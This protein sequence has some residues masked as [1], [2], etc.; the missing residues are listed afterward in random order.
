MPKEDLRKTED[1]SVQQADVPVASTEI[2]AIELPWWRK[3]LEASGISEDVLAKMGASKPYVVSDPKAV[4]FDILNNPEG[5]T[6]SGTIEPRDLGEVLAFPYPG[7]TFERDGREIPFTRI[8]P[9]CPRLAGEFREWIKNADGTKRKL[10]A[11]ERMQLQNAEVGEETH[12]GTLCSGPSGYWCEDNRKP[13]KYESPRKLGQ[14]IYDVIDIFHPEG[15]RATDTLY[16]IEGEK[17]ALCANANLGLKAYGLSGV[18][19]AHDIEATQTA[20]D[21]GSGSY[22]LH[23]KILAHCGRG[24]IVTTMFD[25]PDVGKNPQV[26]RAQAT[27]LRAVLKAGGK[28]EITYMPDDLEHRR[29][30]GIDD[31]FVECG[32]E[33]VLNRVFDCPAQPFE[34]LKAYECCEKGDIMNQLPRCLSLHAGAWFANDRFLLKKWVR[35]ATKV[36]DTEEEQVMEWCNE[37]ARVCQVTSQ[38]RIIKD[39]ER[40][41]ELLLGK[42]ELRMDE[43]TEEIYLGKNLLRVDSAVTK[44]RANLS[45]V[46]NRIGADPSRDDV[47]DGIRHIAERSSFHPVREYLEDLPG[48]DRATRMESAI[49]HLGIAESSRDPLQAVLFRKFLIAGVARTFEPGCKVDTML[50]LHGPQGVQKSSLFRALCSAP[51]WFTDQNFAVGDKDAVLTINRFWIV[52]WS[53]L[54]NLRRASRREELKGFVSRSVD[55]VRPPYGRCVV[56]MK[57]SCI[58]CGTT[59]EEM[60]LDD[61]TGHRR[62]WI[63]SDV[64]NVDVHWFEK[65]RDLLWAEALAAYRAEEKWWLDQSQEERLKRLQCRHEVPSQWG[66]IIEDYLT[67]P[68]VVPNGIG[69]SATLPPPQNVTIT[70]V[71]EKAIGKAKDRQNKADQREV[72]EVLKSLGWRK[73]DSRHRSNNRQVSW[74]MPSPTTSLAAVGESGGQNVSL[75]ATPANCNGVQTA[76]GLMMGEEHSIAPREGFVVDELEPLPAFCRAAPM[77]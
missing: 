13:I 45:L 29:K 20:M 63:I 9:K 65:N 11:R 8:K 39:I 30:R 15:L 19:G 72:A 33:R 67:K 50:I 62:F 21:L 22:I 61:A 36:F 32:R 17:K 48:W 71:L 51:S 24:G 55:S 75:D 43:R 18:T 4:W 28:A 40:H 70:Q 74:R 3:D 37:T 42:G 44:I 73:D 35:K 77:C 12:G 53:E 58:F 7:E 1:R 23:A 5:E 27:I 60:F 69:G 26:V 76:N 56:D 10:T 38:M 57:R 66:D 59:N 2:P 68:R 54:D 6:E 14:R 64:E 25:S 34:S 47:R 46:P 31:F 52:E 41:G 16:L 49:D